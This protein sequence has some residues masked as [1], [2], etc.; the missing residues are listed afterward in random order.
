MKKLIVLIMAFALV[1]SA[2]LAEAGMANPWAETTADGLMEKLGLQFGV[3]EGATDVRYRMMEAEKLAEMTFT[4]DDMEYTARIKPAAAFEDISGLYYS[5][6]NVEEDD[7]V[8]GCPTWEAR[9]EDGDRIVDLC[10]WY[11]AAPGLM[12]SLN[13]SGPDHLDGFDILAAAQQ[14]YV[15]VQGDA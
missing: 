3:P 1:C 11:D 8:G 7:S 12:Y 9:A 5:W 10:L 15:P 2:A 6:E 4:W 14:V 13:T